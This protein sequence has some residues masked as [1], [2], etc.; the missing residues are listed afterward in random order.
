MVLGDPCE[1]IF[2]SQRG[3]DLQVEKHCLKPLCSSMFSYVLACSNT[4]VHFFCLQFASTSRLTCASSALCSRTSNPCL[5]VISLWGD[6]LLLSQTPPYTTDVYL[7][8]LSPGTPIALSPSS[9]SG[10]C[11]NITQNGISLKTLQVTIR[12]S[13]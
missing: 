2:N 12:D 5:Q 6:R 13:I 10:F 1:R 7:G 8:L 4:L 3:R 11:F 9:F